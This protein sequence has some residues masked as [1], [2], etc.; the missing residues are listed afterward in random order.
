MDSVKQHDERGK[1]PSTYQE[2][3]S[4]GWFSKSTDQRQ[5]IWSQMHMA[6]MLKYSKAITQWD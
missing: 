1:D 4:A 2:L 6:K 3:L 5:L